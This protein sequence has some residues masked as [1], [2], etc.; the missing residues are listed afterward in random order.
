MSQAHFTKQQW[1]ALPLA[2]RQRWW[3]ETD[4]GMKPPSTELLAE[5]RRMVEEM[6]RA[7]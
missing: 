1:F 7:G 3:A 2:F 6:E 5:G 4:Y